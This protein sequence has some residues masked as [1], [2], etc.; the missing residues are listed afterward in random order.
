[1][2][3][4]NKSISE[5]CPLAWREFQTWSSQKGNEEVMKT[6]NESH[7]FRPL[8]GYYFDFFIN[9]AKHNDEIKRLIMG[10][11]PIEPVSIRKNTI[12]KLFVKLE[13]HIRSV[14]NWTYGG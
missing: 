8:I 5:I 9:Y 14:E 2:I 7:D 1:M 13:S 6:F 10:Y 11:S 4:E 12:Y 3:A